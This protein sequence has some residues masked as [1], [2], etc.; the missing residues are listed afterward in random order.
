MSLSLEANEKAWQELERFWAK[1][2][3]QM[4]KL[5]L[6]R[7]YRTGELFKATFLD[8]PEITQTGGDFQGSTLFG[9]RIFCDYPLDLSKAFRSTEYKW[10][11]ENVRPMKGGSGYEIHIDCQ[12]NTLEEAVVFLL[13][14]LHGALGVLSLSEDIK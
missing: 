8:V 3:A 2:A 4:K 7:N 1:N 10:L 9:P 12:F 13:G 14:S 6:T 11:I 5:H